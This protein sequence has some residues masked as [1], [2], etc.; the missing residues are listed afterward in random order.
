LYCFNKIIIIITKLITFY[1]NRHKVHRERVH[2]RRD[3]SKIRSVSDISS[4]YFDGKKDLTFIN[5]KCGEKYYRKTISEEHI[6][7]ITEPESK[8]LGHFTPG[9][10]SSLSIHSGI[11]RFVEEKRLSMNSLVAIGCDGTNVNTGMKNGVIKRI[12]DTLGRPLHWFICML[13][14][15]ELPLRHLFNSL[16]GK[17]SG[18]RSFTGPIGK[19]LQKCE[20]KVIVSFTPIEVPVISIEKTDLS[21]DQ[22]YMHEMY[23]AIS[24]GLLSDDLAKRSPGCLNHARWLTTANRILRLYVSSNEPSQS[25][26]TLVEFVMLVY[27]PMWFKIKANPYVQSGAMHLYQTAKLMK[28]QSIAVQKI[29]FPVLQR[30]A[31]FGHPENILLSMISDSRPHIR[32]L[33]WRRIKNARA[34]RKDPSAGARIFKIPEIVVECRDYV[35][36]IDWKNVEVTEPPITMNV[37]DSEVDSFILDKTVFD[38]EKYPLHTQAVERTIKL[39]SDA[40]SRVCG[41]DSRDGYIHT[42]LASRERIPKFESRKDYLT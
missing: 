38:F 22:K 29:V 21:T 32:E 11:T 27:I 19:E 3:Q 34:A 2:R 37:T 6:C 41:Q 10:G 13:H 17:T 16:D 31:Y 42:R 14:A 12:E 39:V 33:A 25:L 4:I 18:P 1:S 30:N 7:L 35:N 40:S 9:T 20:A 5:Q 28:E 15:N 24:R 26:I 23:D 36:M 8:Y